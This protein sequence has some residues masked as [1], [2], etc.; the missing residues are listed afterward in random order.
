MIDRWKHVGLAL[1]LDSN[2]LNKIEKENRDLDDCL[3]AM[4]TL[5]LK[6]NYDTEK[7]GEPSWELL[8]G[9]VRHPAGGKNSAL[10]DSIARK[11]GGIL[12]LKFCVIVG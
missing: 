10:A 5:W 12:Y 1:K 6:K 7:H 3:T 2:Q 4:L 8:S 11:Y 9:A